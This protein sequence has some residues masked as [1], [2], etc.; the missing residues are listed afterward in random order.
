VGQRRGTRLITL[1]KINL[2]IA[3]TILY[4]WQSQSLCK[5]WETINNLNDLK[6]KE[7]PHNNGT[8]WRTN[9]PGLAKV[10]K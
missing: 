2:N 9:L 1:H 10:G 7:Q 3:F 5:V 6:N 4:G 8:R